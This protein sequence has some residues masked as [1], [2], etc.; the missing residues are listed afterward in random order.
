MSGAPNPPVPRRRRVRRRRRPDSGLGCSPA[1][2]IVGR[3]RFDAL[4]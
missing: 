2:D 3:D 4:S 1:A